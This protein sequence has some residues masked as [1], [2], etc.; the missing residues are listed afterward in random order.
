MP[1][2]VQG[3]SAHH[4]PRKAKR[5]PSFPVDPLAESTEDCLCLACRQVGHVVQSCPQLPKE[6]LQRVKIPAETEGACPSH[7]F[8]LPFPT[9]EGSLGSLCQRCNELEVGFSGLAGARLVGSSGGHIQ[10]AVM[11]QTP[12]ASLGPLRTLQLFST[13]PL[14]RLIFDVTYLSEDDLMAVTKPI[15]TSEGH[16]VL[17]AM[18]T[19]MHVISDIQPPKE[20]W[21]PHTICAYTQVTRKR[22]PRFG[23]QDSE[24]TGG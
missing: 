23:C 16:L 21:G 15:N 3:R 6:D 9:T 17:S 4:L 24:P 12:I 1:R 20:E 7:P 19:L 10:Q 2:K 13:C 18:W 11:R 5:R 22:R 14:C 8:N